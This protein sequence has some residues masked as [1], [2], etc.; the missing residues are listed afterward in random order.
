LLEELPLSDLLS[1]EKE[2]AGLYLSGHPM[3][4]YAHWYKDRRFT[5][6][7]RLLSAAEEGDTA[8]GDG[9]TVILLGLVGT[10]REQHTKSGAKMAYAR[11]EDLYGSVELVLFPK[12]LSQY[13]KLLEAGSILQVTG[14]VDLREDEPPKILCEQI[15]LLPPP[16]KKEKQ[17]APKGL[18]LRVSGQTDP[19][20]MQ[21]LQTLTAFHGE[22]DVYVR[23]SDSGKLV[24]LGEK[25]RIT[26][27]ETL[28]S[29]L[30]ELLGE[31]NVAER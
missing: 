21:S 24:R 1:M 22:Q 11:L 19:L 20:Y 4:P 18:Y 7:S 10:V 28:L 12:V 5:R 2:V 30:K 27:C 31:E 29:T 23:F 15:S 3:T 9:T 17:S 8:I 6:T 25:Y 26:P 16:E 14:R 13:G